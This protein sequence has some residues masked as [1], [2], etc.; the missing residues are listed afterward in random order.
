MRNKCPRLTIFSKTC[1]DSFGDNAMDG[2][3]QIIHRSSRAIS[4]CI[5]CIICINR[6]I[7]NRT[8]PDN[9]RILYDPLKDSDESQ[10]SLSG[11][12]LTGKCLTHTL[13]DEFVCIIECLY[14]QLFLAREMIIDPALLQPGFTHNVS[15]RRAK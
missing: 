12:Q 2:A 7:E 15:E 9:R 8:T 1:G 5:I 13:L 14:S 4:Q 6:C 10:E 11:M 3:A